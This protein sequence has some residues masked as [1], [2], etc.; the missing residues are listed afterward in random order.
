LTVLLPVFFTQLLKP[1]VQKPQSFVVFIFLQRNT[2]VSAI[3]LAL[4]EVNQEE[5]KP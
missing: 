4:R 1:T 5:E 3:R 2:M